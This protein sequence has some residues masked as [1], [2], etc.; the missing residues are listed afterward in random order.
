M[1]ATGWVPDQLL[2]GLSGSTQ[3]ATPELLAS[4]GI[5]TGGNFNAADW[6]W[7]PDTRQ[8]VNKYGQGSYDYSWN[9]LGGDPSLGTDVVLPYGYTGGNQGYGDP[10]GTN[11]GNTYAGFG[12]TYHF[13]P[14]QNPYFGFGDGRDMFFSADP[15]AID[16]YQHDAQTRVNQGILTTAA[17]V[18]GGAALSGLGAGAG[19]GTA[20]VSASNTAAGVAAGAGSGSL[21]PAAG[22]AGGMAGAPAV[23]GAGTAAAGLG[24][25]GL[26]GWL[27]LGSLGAQA[28]QGND[29]IT[30]NSTNAPPAYIAPYLADAAARSADLYG[31]GNYVAPVQ[32]AAINYGTNVLSGNYLNSN[33]YLDATFN[34]AAGAVTN[35]V[36][37]NFAGAGRNAQGAD[38]AGFATDGYNNLATQIY[39]G[40]YQAER[41]RMQQLVPLAGQLGSY[42]NPGAGLDDY[43]ARLRNIGGGYGSSTSSTPTESNWLSGLAGLGLALMPRPGA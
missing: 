7:N 25:L 26:G 42:T 29:D 14:G 38:A 15:N 23:A 27:T 2:S 21:I 20:T 3:Q 19:S 30:T 32:N 43:I 9:A 6:N 18:G 17:L 31:Q 5:P 40:N 11:V 37:S 33:P 4:L 8:L 12:D 24:G 35:Q 36:Q 22:V 28:L 13:D 16:Q 39:G 10:S 41:D 1:T 34:K